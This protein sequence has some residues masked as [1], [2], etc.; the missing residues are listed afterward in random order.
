MTAELWLMLLV[1]A[2]NALMFHALPRLS[3]PDILFAVTVP[4]AFASSGDAAAVVRRYRAVVWLSTLVVAGVLV[5]SPARSGRAAFVGMHIAIVLG[6][7][8]W[9]N[10]RVRPHAAIEPAVRVATVAPR[11]THLPGGALFAAGPL[12]VLTAAAL[13]LWLNWD[14]IPDRVP[15][16]WSVE[17]TPTGFRTKGVSGVYTGLTIGAVVVSM[18][19]A[20]AWAIVAR[21]RQV[22]IDGAAAAGERRF[23]GVSALQ[24]LCSA[25]ATAGL[26]AAFSVG[27]V[28]RGTDRLP[29]FILVLLGAAVALS[30]GFVLV[31]VW[32]GQGGQRAVAPDARDGIH[33]DA[34]PDAAWK[35]GFLY[36]NPNDPA[37]VVEKRMGI[38]WTLNMANRWSW[39]IVGAAV[40]AIVMSNVL[41]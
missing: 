33:G 31:M 38:G 11:D 40:L 12:I 26:S 4:G 36:Y 37:L 18:M 29:P 23:K 32:L 20:M 15:S 8:V 14:L 30:S 21:T 22:A 34:T 7:W 28:I 3:R 16:R 19:L 25:Y 39:L 10:R 5:A 9:A 27:P 6:A 41:R 35:G 13:F 2:V 17:G 1:V 24:L